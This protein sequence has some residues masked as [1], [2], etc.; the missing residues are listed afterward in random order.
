M[1]SRPSLLSEHLWFIL[2]LVACLGWL[3]NLKKSDLVPSWQFKYLGLGFNTELALVR[4]SLKHVERMEVCI[5]LF[6]WQP[7]QPARAVLQLL[8]HMVSVADPTHLGR[9]HT[10]PV[11]SVAT[12]SRFTRSSSLLGSGGLDLIICLDG[13]L[14]TTPGVAFLSTPWNPLSH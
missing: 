12:S 5:H 9:L 13:C 4:P 14:W 2:D 11:K 6:L 8:G 3:V 10:L 1:P 7:C